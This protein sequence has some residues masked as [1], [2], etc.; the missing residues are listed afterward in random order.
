MLAEDEKDYELLRK[1]INRVKDESDHAVPQIGFA[2]IVY[3]CI[4]YF[5]SFTTNPDGSSQLGYCIPLID[6]SGRSALVKFR[7]GKCYRVTHS[8]M[9]WKTRAFD[10]VCDAAFVVRHS[11]ETMLKQQIRLQM[12]N[13]SKKLFHPISNSTH[14][15]KR[16]I[17]VDIATA[18]Q[19]FERTEISDLVLVTTKIMLADC[20][21]ELM[22]P[23][24]LL[25]ALNFGPLHHEIED[26]VIG[27]V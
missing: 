20:F 16:C 27:D 24:Q 2:C 13:N 19:S 1:C 15:N 25:L 11:L 5:L 18:K 23:K 26:W 10:E 4:R 22:E 9:A 14:A 21:T 6:A 7:S 8:A 17:L 3:S 12:L